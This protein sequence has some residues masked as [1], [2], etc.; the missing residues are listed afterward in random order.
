MMG[1]T[2]SSAGANSGLAGNNLVELPVSPSVYVFM[3]RKRAMVPLG[4]TAQPFIGSEIVTAFRLTESVCFQPSTRA[5]ISSPLGPTATAME[6]FTTE[7]PE[8]K[9]SGNGFASSHV[10]PPSREIAADRAE[11]DGSL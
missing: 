4:P 5:P 9:P 3:P 7:T 11:R 10:L 2:W 6:S 8:R 1:E